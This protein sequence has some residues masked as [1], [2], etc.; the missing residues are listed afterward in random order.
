MTEWLGIEVDCREK[1]RQKAVIAVGHRMAYLPHSQ[2][3]LRRKYL[4]CKTTL[5]SGMVWNVQIKYLKRDAKDFKSTINYDQGLQ[6][7]QMLN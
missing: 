5:K 1:G 7:V 2:C 6:H 3:G 4:E